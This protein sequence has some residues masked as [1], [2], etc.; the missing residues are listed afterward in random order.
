MSESLKTLGDR[1]RRA[2]VESGLSQAQ[3]GAPHFTR[4]YVSALELGKIRP[5]MKSL[6]FLASKLGKPAGHFLEDEEQEKR[7]LERELDLK[8]AAALLS[9]PTAAEALTRVSKLLESTTDP[10][11]ICR[12]R[13]MAGTAHNFLAHGAEAIRELTIAEKL[14][15]HAADAHVRR[16]VTHQ[17]AIALRLVGE[18]TRARDILLGLL[19]EAEKAAEPDRIFRMKLLRD[20]GAVSW[21]LGDYAKATGY[22]Q[23]ALEWAKD[24]GDVAGL[25]AIYNGL[26]YAQRAMGDLEGATAYLQKAL[27]AT[28]VSNDLTAAAVL[29]NALAVLAAERGHMDAAYRH[30]DRAIELARVSGPESYVAHYLTTKAECALKVNAN[31][32]ADRF[33]SEAIALAERTRNRRAAAAAKVVLAEVSSRSGAVDASAGRLEEAAGIYRGIGA[34]QELGEV[35]M[36]LSELARARG[37]AEHAR[38]YAEEAYRTTK[39]ASGLVGR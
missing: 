33:A 6:E 4:A 8:A 16:G 20:L 3:L 13:L 10:A 35:L 32:D 19:D 2:R 22:Y 23:A 36:R 1:L 17:M 25:I 26:A 39:T 29:H 31:A 12:L 28:Q 27:G 37:D 7:R 30:V 18:L 11:E 34:K 24:I 14:A 9:R 15:R 38:E 5:A 21:D